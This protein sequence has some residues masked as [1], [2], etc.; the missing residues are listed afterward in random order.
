MLVGKLWVDR[1]LT[2]SIVGDI[3]L[4]RGVGEV[5]SENGF[6]YP[7]E[8][9]KN[10]LQSDDIT[11]GN[12]ECAITEEKN[13]AIK[14]HSIVFKADP[15]NAKAL[16]NAG[17][18]VLSLANNHTMDYLPK[19]LQDTMEYLAKENIGYVGVKNNLYTNAESYIIKKK[20][21]SV[22]ILGYNTLPIEG[23]FFSDDDVRIAYARIGFLENMATQI[24]ETKNK[25]DYLI[26]YFHFGTEFRTEVS[27]KQREYAY[28][29]IEA[30]ADLIVGAHPHLLQE[31]ELYKDK[32][33]YYS[34][35]SFV[36]DKFDNNATDD[37]IILQVKLKGNE[38]SIN[39]IPIMIM[40]CQP[41]LVTGDDKA[42]ILNRIHPNG[43]NN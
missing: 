15:Q 42:R 43:V 4:S 37:S 9:T 31:M 16:K 40:K 8:K 10:I 17:V 13:H 7:Y 11:I 33:I 14:K 39:E 25:C 23:E 30:G 27:E 26:V 35:G 24:R 2:I 32:P 1:E 18:D 21:K 41:Y 20:G 29:A 34:L 5:I 19:G 12:L 22:G 36:F 6:H 28:S 3:L 38:I